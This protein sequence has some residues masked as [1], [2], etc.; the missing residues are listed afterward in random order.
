M[1]VLPIVSLP[2]SF[3]AVTGWQC[4]YL[5]NM[6]VKLTVKNGKVVK[7]EPLID[8]PDVQARCSQVGKD[9]IETVIS[10]TR[11]REYK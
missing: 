7:V 8:A 6:V 4:S 11:G 5:T 10:T 3:E 9:V 2:D 1:K